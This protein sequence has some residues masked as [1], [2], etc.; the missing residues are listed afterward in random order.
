MQ[1]G[2]FFK[3]ARNRM[4]NLRFTVRDNSV[5]VEIHHANL[6][7]GVSAQ[8]ILQIRELLNKHRVVVFANQQMDDEQLKD[9]AFRIGPPFV[10]DQRMPV[11]GS[12]EEKT[13]HVLVV[14]NQAPEYKRTYLGCQEV[15]PHSDHQ[16]L[17]CPSAVSLLYAVDISDQSPPTTW[18]D[19]AHA[20]TTLDTNTRSLI[21]DLRLITYNPFFRPFGSVRAHYVDRTT[22]IPP[23]DTFAHPLV[24]TH[25]ETREK[26][27]YLNAAYEVELVGVE[28]KAGKALV[29]RLQA[30]VEESRLRYAH[31]WKRGDLVLWDNR[32][33]LHYRPAFESSVR[34]VLKRVSIAGSIPV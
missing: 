10:V 8:H 25:L 24:T 34:R 5:G 32:A 11:L 7:F 17:R 33:T 1:S 2:Y 18:I 15:L 14:A 9:F 31:Q 21:D 30:H 16:W 6:G 28:Y 23:G 20:Y 4:S 29:A 19:M 3:I 26:I 13:D 22:E 12:D 27:L